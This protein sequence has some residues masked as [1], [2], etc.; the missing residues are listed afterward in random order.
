[1]AGSHSGMYEDDSFLGC[2]AVYFRS[3]Q[4]FQRCILP[5]SSWHPD[6]GGRTDLLQDST[7]PYPKRLSSLKSIFFCLF[8]LDGDVYKLFTQINQM[9]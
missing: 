8:V 9:T 5:P 2:S 6:N 7:A 3:R 4:M 1:M